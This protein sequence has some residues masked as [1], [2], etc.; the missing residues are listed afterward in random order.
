MT[1]EFSTAQPRSAQVRTFRYPDI[2]WDA[3]SI[4]AGSLFREIGRSEVE[5]EVPD[6][7]RVE[8]ERALPFEY[9]PEPG[10]ATEGDFDGGEAE[11]NG[12]NVG[13]P[14]DAA[15]GR[16]PPTEE[17]QQFQQLM[18]SECRKAEERGRDEGWDQ[19]RESGLAEGRQQGREEAARQLQAGVEEERRRMRSQAA[20]LLESFAE[21]RE[22]YCRRLERESARL[23]LAIAARVLRR[24]AQADPLLL[25]GAVRVALGQLAASTA[26][27]MRVP[28]ADL[29]LWR[30][31]MAHMPNLAVRPEVIGDPEMEVGDCRLETELGS[32]ELG[33]GPQLAVLEREFFAEGSNDSGVAGETESPGD[34]VS[35]RN[36]R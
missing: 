2:P 10:F 31:A 19:G 28:A 1:G 34:D 16:N 30:E 8:E 14:A 24:E 9:P 26:V 4:P 5:T 36:L 7:L 20:A 17:Q 3:G 12:L 23:A 13:E 29:D 33:L 27:R 6:S 35:E 15:D 11:D 25:T 32:A 18:T 21:V 22:G